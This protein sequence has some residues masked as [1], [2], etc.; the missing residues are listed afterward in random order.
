MPE[1][2]ALLF[3]RNRLCCTYLLKIYILKEHNDFIKPGY[4]NSLVPTYLGNLELN[5]FSY[6]PDS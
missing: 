3:F 4:I 2:W 6:F 1:P 5:L